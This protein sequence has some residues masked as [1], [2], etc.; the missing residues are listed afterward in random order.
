MYEHMTTMHRYRLLTAFLMLATSMTALAQDTSNTIGKVSISSPTAASLGKFGDIP[1]SYHTG[2]PN[3]GIPIYTVTNG[4]IS[5][6][7]SLNYHASGLK[8]QEPAGWVGAG[9]AL[10]AG[11]V[12]TRTVVG[13]PDERN[14]NTGSSSAFGH[15]SDY[16]FN[17]YIYA[18]NGIPDYEAFSK[19]FKDGEPDLFFFNFGGY[20]GK[21]FFRDD[22]TPV[23]L[24]EQDLRIVPD[25]DS[26]RTSALYGFTITT[27]DGVQYT[28]GCTGNPGTIVPVEV[29]TPISSTTGSS[30]TS[31][32]SSW[33][34]NKISSPDNLFSI[35]LAY[36]AENYGCFSLSMFPLDGVYDSNKPYEYDL[37][38]NI[39]Q[40]VRLSKISFPNGTVN[41]MPGTARI[42]LSDNI[43]TVT[44]GTNQQAMSLGSVQVS[45]SNGF[46]KRY[47]FSYGY[48]GDTTTNNLTGYLPYMARS[49]M[50]TDRLRLRLDTLTES[51]CDGSAVVPPHVFTYFTEPVPRRLSFGIDHWG[52]YN[53][54]D[55]NQTL[56]PTYYL[57]SPSNPSTVAGA[58]RDAAFP[59]MRGG[60]LHRI[61]YPTGGSSTFEFGSNLA[62]AT[63]TTYG[64]GSIGNLTVHWY[65][66]GSTTSTISMTVTGT[67]STSTVA[68]LASINNYT[69]SNGA[70]Y[71][72]PHLTVNNS[73]NSVVYSYDVN[74][75]TLTLQLLPG[76]YSVTLAYPANAAF[77]SGQGATAGFTQ[78]SS[79]TTSQNAVVG[80]LCIQSVTNNDGATGNSMV[81][82]YSYQVNGKST[83]VLYGQPVYLGIIRNDMLEGTGYW[84]VNGFTPSKVPWVLGGCTTGPSASFFKSPSSIQPMASTQGNPI[85]YSHVEVSQT[86][87][88]HSAYEY[89]GTAPYQL[90]NGD[91]AVTSLNTDGCNTAAPNYPP[92]PL[93][94][95][96]TRGELKY[97][98]HY[99]QSG[100]LLKDASY[101]QTYQNSATSTPAF[102]ARWQ[103]GPILA[104]I[105]SL[106]SA[107]KVSDRMVQTSYVPG[108]GSLSTT[109]T[110]YYSSA[111]HHQ[112]TRRVV[113]TSTGDSMATNLLYAHDIRAATCDTISDGYPKYISDC[114][115]CQT[116]Y[117]SARAQCASN[118]AQCFTTA[119]LNFLQCQ[120]N[121]R[122][123]YVA[124]RKI[125]FTNT[126]NTFQTN[127][128]NAK[129]GANSELKPVLELQDEYKNL[130][131][132]TS[133]YKNSNL[134]G[135]LFTR[136]DYVANPV[137]IVYPNRTQSISLQDVSSSFLP[138]AA[139]GSTLSKDP[140]Y[141]DETLYTFDGGNLG[142]ARTKAGVTTAYLWG[143]NNSL[144]IAK[145]VGMSHANLVAAYGA[146][147]GNLSTIRS[148]SQIAGALVSTY[149][150]VPL[151][152]MSSE[153]GADGRA[154]AYSYDGLGRLVTVRDFAGNLIKQI[155]YS[156]SGQLGNCGDSIYSNFA[157]STTFTRNNCTSGG[158]GGNTTYTVPAGRYHSGLGQADAEQQAAN[159]AGANGQ[160]YANA[161]ASCTY[162]NDIQ[163]GTYT[164]SNCASGQ[165]AGSYTYT[166]QAATYTSTVSK[167]DAN[168]KATND[169][170]ANGQ[171]AANANG[172]C[173]AANFTITANNYVGCSCF[174]ATFTNTSTSVQTGFNIGAG[175][176]IIGNLPA[177]VYNVTLSQ[178]QNGQYI[179]SVCDLNQSGV[180]SA[181]FS[182][183]SIGSNS[184][185]T[186]SFDN[187]NG[188]DVPNQN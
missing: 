156:Y 14:N 6:P 77:S 165:T 47:R 34:L 105:Y 92:A 148:Q 180:S 137:G 35:K 167:T 140:R 64:Q 117:N 24:P 95:D 133:Q 30:P 1:V 124:Y 76:T 96:Y 5:L 111:F 125:N 128:N 23:I 181:T 41:F 112:V 66:Q 71:Y 3:I 40:G 59:A 151:V 21:F 171:A 160:A 80:G 164:R 37:V 12:I 102:I 25:Y 154:T 44:D 121:A 48:F 49:P 88:G 70:S 2:I 67:S 115:T 135:A 86:G 158:Q 119:Y 72:T 172:T 74:T 176:G 18:S 162:T 120:T 147:R 175:G 84:G 32:V 136:Y 179:Y 106:A 53:G 138:A 61:T 161:N 129:S 11:G 13:A 55:A 146:S 54:Q 58:I 39:V 8:V 33:Y 166:V 182:N 183:V 7:I 100:N 83:A 132:E 91:V 107:R 114:S 27:P 168:Q 186:I 38:K 16:G 184:C 26:S 57:T 90:S 73:N 152:G 155:C 150:Y 99:D 22:R 144:P 60:M 63:H 149:A 188:G 17:S 31:V 122:V 101:A 36:V 174:F 153:T 19:G 68:V 42:D 143:Y 81:T 56:I 116:A 118:D 187:A 15:F 170:S 94:F 103:G 177:G 65:G 159:D 113:G 134:L 110:N 108:G 4:P 52:F 131:L 28:F 62:Y 69:G 169:I 123:S 10:E 82:G 93:A 109:T 85:G 145:A 9:W 29:S 50:T 126:S 89:Y 130:V 75:T 157:R 45:D 173:T 98:A 127:H 104:T 141:V 185:N 142:D 43:P 20:S 87:N 78:W 46:C 97:E 79:S 178:T 51:S 163:N 139:N